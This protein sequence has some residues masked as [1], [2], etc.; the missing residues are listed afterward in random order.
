MSDF[1][2]E[3][4]PMTLRF[5]TDGDDEGVGLVSIETDGAGHIGTTAEITRDEWDA[6]REAAAR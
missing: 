4:G 1:E 3:L 2:I 6:T 5:E